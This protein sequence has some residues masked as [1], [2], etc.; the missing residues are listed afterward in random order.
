MKARPIFAL[1][2]LAASLSCFADD[3][4][5]GA[6]VDPATP[7]AEAQSAPPAESGPSKGTLDE[8]IVGAVDYVVYPLA[9]NWSLHETELAQDR[10]LVD[11]KL[12]RLHRGG[13]GGALQVLKLRADEIARKGGFSSYRIARYEE[14]I[15]SGWIAQRTAVGELVFSR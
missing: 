15:D 9:P 13:D 11:L 8:V 3:R 7:Q 10:V 5:V 12:N 1:A 14:G 4:I 2:L 6:P